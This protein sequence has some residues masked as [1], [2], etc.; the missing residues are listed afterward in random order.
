MFFE[1]LP[2]LKQ[3][4]KVAFKWYGNKDADYI[5]RIEMTQHGEPFW[6]AEH[7]Y[8]ENGD[9]KVHCEG[10]RWYNSLRSFHRFTE[11]EIPKP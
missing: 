6:V 11:F 2:P 10:M 3:G 9:I 1:D 8:D 4:D 5:G 7:N